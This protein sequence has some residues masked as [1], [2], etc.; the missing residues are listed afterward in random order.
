[1]GGPG[2]GDWHQAEFRF[3]AEL[4]DFLPAAARQRPLPYRFR[5][6]PAIKDPIEALGVPHPE[7]ELI[8]ANG[9]PVGFDY[10]LADAD[11]IAVYPVFEAFDVT[12]LLRLRERPLR[13]TA[14]V[15][16]VNLGRLARHLRLLGFDASYRNDLDDAEIVRRAVGERRIVLTRD[17]KLLCDGALTHGYWVRSSAPAEQLDE[18]LWRFDLA[19]A[20]HPFTR[21]LVCNGELREADAAEVATAVPADVRATQERYRACP[22]CQRVYWRGSHHA[23]LQQLV[24]R[25][26]ER[27][28]RRR[29]AAA[30]G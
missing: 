21:C 11:R 9:V 3:Y 1:M 23:R 28:R 29:A 16:D 22:G 8:L 24:E 20:C 19:A 15:V 2:A 6:T 27:A 30:E 12:P 26:L 4:N 18:V 10:R 5:G 25:S 17:R 14:F 7:V 13:R